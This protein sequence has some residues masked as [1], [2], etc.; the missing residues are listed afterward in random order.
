MVGRTGLILLQALR[1]R[2][3]DP[4]RSW[5]DSISCGLGYASSPTWSR[6]IVKTSV[7]DIDQLSR[8]LRSTRLMLQRLTGLIAI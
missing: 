1:D 5:T 6:C 8:A 7:L 3:L 4:T 2:A